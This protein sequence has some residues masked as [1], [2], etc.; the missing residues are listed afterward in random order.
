MQLVFG[1]DAAVAAFAAERLALTI[2]PPY[3]AIGVADETGLKGAAV[4]NNWNRWQ[5]EIS[6]YGPGCLT[7]PVIR[8][9]LLA[10][11]FDD[12]GAGRVT[13]RTRRSNKTMQ[14][15]FPRLG[16]EMEGVLKRFYGPTKADD[17]FIYRLDRQAAERWR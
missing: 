14:R 4:Y 17:A 5:I 13:A 6:F 2:S 12:L 11:P 15:L 10:Y 1:H 3:V 7:R 9:F 8:S 16:F